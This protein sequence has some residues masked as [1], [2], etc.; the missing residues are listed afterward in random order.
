MKTLIAVTISAGLL[1]LV[2][3]AAESKVKMENLPPAVQQAVKEQSKGAQLVGLAKE[4]E[5]GKTTYEAE[6]KVD[7]HGKDVSFDSTGKIVSVEEEV[8]LASLP[9]P[10]RAAIQKAVGNGKL[11]KVESVQEN[12]TTSYEASIKKGGKSSEFKV[13]AKGSP[14]K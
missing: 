9:E 10:A 3:F 13:D 11:Q 14:I 1:S 5:N 4:V 8:T 6:L 2:S 12:G 7:G